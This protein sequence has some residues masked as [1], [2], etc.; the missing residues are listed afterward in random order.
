MAQHR[1]LASLAEIAAGNRRGVTPTRQAPSGARLLHVATA[2]CGCCRIP[3]DCLKPSPNCKA[4]LR[5]CTPNATG[6]GSLCQQGSAVRSRPH[7]TPTP[8]R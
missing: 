4:L 5:H 1:S 3:G 6:H 8:R 7:S 2:D